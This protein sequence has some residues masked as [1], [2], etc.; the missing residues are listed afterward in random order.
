MVVGPVHYRSHNKDEIS[1]QGLCAS[2]LDGLHAMM[3]LLV[4]EV[5][6]LKTF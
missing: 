6:V 1:Q 3:P 4:R 2:I 5:V